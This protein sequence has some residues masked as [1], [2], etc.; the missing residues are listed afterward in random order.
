MFLTTFITNEHLKENAFALETIDLLVE[1][2]ELTKWI[3]LNLSFIL[4]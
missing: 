3:R 2:C 1:L 4:N